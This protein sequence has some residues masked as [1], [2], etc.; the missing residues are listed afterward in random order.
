MYRLIKETAADLPQITDAGVSTVQRNTQ[1]KVFGSSE[2]LSRVDEWAVADI[3]NEG[4]ASRS[5]GQT[6]Q[7]KYPPLRETLLL[8]LLGPLDS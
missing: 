5:K 2:M 6:E 8:I 1:W 4:S 7:A 3:S